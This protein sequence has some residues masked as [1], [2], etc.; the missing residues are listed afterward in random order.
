MIQHARDL[1]KGL[2]EV[3]MAAA[4]RMTS[5]QVAKMDADLDATL[6]TLKV[7]DKDGRMARA[8][9]ARRL[10]VIR[11]YVGVFASHGHLTT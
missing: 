10:D 3:R 6:R 9:L 1:Q 2:E 8:A 5:A 7:V 11:A 4:G